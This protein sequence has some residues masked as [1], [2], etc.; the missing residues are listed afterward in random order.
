MK[1]RTQDEVDLSRRAFLK[2][3][4]LLGLTL[5]ALSLPGL[6]CPRGLRLGPAAIGGLALDEKIDA[7]PDGAAAER[8]GIAREARRAISPSAPTRF[9]KRC[10]PLCP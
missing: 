8:G 1:H 3:G 4:G 5:G 2:V 10:S 6:S 9:A 7:A